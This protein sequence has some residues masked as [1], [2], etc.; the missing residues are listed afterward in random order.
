MSLE[1]ARKI[2]TR[3]H[4]GRRRAMRTTAKIA[5]TVLAMAH[6]F[7]GAVKAQEMP[8]PAQQDHAQHH[9]GDVRPVEAQYPRMG[10]AQ[11][12]AQGRLVTLGEVEKI[13]R[14]MNPTMRQAGA[15]IRAARARQPQP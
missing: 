6:V 15:H 12:N 5:V 7:S 9:H 3:D 11:T 2:C 14:D 1:T 10:L 13:A 4:R 8:M